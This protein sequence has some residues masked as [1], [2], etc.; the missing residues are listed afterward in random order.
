VHGQIS[1][2]SERGEILG[3]HRTAGPDVYVQGL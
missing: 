3:G 2:D 1:G